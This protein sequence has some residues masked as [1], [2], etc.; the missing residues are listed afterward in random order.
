M[1]HKFDGPMSLFV[2]GC[3]VSLFR[4]NLSEVNDGYHWI[5]LVN[6]HFASVGH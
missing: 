4:L 6:T 3:S 1:K 5:F 2:M